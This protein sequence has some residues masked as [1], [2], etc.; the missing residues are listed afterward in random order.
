[1][2]RVMLPKSVSRFQNTYQ[3][4]EDVVAN[5][6]LV[7]TWP[8]TV[9]VTLPEKL[10]SSYG[11]AK[12][13]K[14]PWKSGIL[15]KST[16]QPPVPFFKKV[17]RIFRSISNVLLHLFFINNQK[18]NLSPQKSLICWTISKQFAGKRRKLNN[19]LREQTKTLLLNRKPIR[20][21]QF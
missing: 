11:L 13:E 4:I 17:S 14:N 3:S 10:G 7:L 19:P 5:S 21:T 2:P 6:L 20:N 15:G 8:S 1:M 18:C 16:G 12:W 9:N